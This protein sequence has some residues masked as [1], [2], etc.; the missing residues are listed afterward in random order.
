MKLIT[1][2]SQKQHWGYTKIEIKD[3][4]KYLS[5]YSSYS[6]YS[7]STVLTFIVYTYT[8]L[9]LFYLVNK[10]LRWEVMI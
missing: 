1:E 6:S 3:Y 8:S 4:I 10:T 9:N 7:Y 5:K 2:R